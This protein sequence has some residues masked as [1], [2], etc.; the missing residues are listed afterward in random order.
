MLIRYTERL[1]EAGLEPSVD[2][3]GDSY[4]REAC[5]RGTT[6]W[7]KASSAYP[8][9]GLGIYR[10]CRT[11]R[12]VTPWLLVRTTEGR[13]GMILILRRLRAKVTSSGLHSPSAQ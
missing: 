13:M 12:S 4:E 11:N 8:P 10:A 6:R 3:V 1:A 2:T 7:P 5:P 9:G